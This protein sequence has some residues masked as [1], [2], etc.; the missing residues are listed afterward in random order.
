MSSVSTADSVIL[1]FDGCS[2]TVPPS[3]TRFC[4]M[5]HER[6]SGSLL[7][8]SWNRTEERLLD[9]NT[10]PGNDLGYVAGS[11]SQ[12]SPNDLQRNRHRC[13]E[14]QHGLRETS[15]PNP[16]H[17]VF[18]SPSSSRFFLTELLVQCVAMG[19]LSRP[20]GRNAGHVARNG[21]RP[22]LERASIDGH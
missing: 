19:L 10:C 13:G 15:I 20:D 17:G 4:G 16:L 14:C 3:F 8:L 21:S 12:R 11:M 9:G 6:R 2:A 1:T 5:I 7:V 18:L 22:A